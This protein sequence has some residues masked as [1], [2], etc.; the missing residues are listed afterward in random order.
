MQF[1]GTTLHGILLHQA[2]PVLVIDATGRT[3]TMPGPAAA[4]MLA[5][6]MVGVG[7]RR[8]IRFVKPCDST[9]ANARRRRADV[10][11][12]V[13]QHVVEHDSRLDPVHRNTQ[14]RGAKLWVPQPTRARTGQGG[15]IVKLRFEKN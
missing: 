8:R 7:N 1:D 12:V 4:R 9:V 14:S 2:E 6:D 11:A 5:D 10:K 3:C 15:R 13:Q